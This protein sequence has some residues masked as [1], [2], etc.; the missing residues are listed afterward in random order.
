MQVGDLVEL[1]SAGKKNKQNVE[2]VGTFG[3]IVAVAEHNQ[4]PY[5]IQWIGL[6]SKTTESRKVL[7]MARYE[8][9]KFRGA[10]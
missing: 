4:Y 9:K 3:M 5:S 6:P 1:S 7:P 2:V 10:K 8:I